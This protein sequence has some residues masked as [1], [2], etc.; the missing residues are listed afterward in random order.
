QDYL[1]FVLNSR[2]TFNTLADALIRKGEYDRASEVLLKCLEVMPNE[3]VSY[4]FFNVQQIDMLIRLSEMKAGY[5]NE[6]D[7]TAELRYAYDIAEVTSNSAVEWL[8]YYFESGGIESNEL[9]KRIFTLNEIARAFRANGD[10][11]NAAKY[12]ALF[13]DYYS[14]LGG[15]R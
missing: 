13:S 6:T 8:D 2:S 4:D 3:S 14:R 15:Q 12:E 10:K 11:E 7:T 5:T 9:Q 1:G